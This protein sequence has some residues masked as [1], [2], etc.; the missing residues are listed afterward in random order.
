MAWIA[1]S[2]RFFLDIEHHMQIYYLLP[3]SWAHLLVKKSVNRN[4]NANEE[5]FYQLGIARHL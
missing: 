1:T 2:F 4:A 5:T 3:S